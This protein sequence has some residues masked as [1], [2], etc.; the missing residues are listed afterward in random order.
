MK[1]PGFGD[2]ARA[3]HE[4]QALEEER[5]GDIQNLGHQPQPRGGDAVSTAFVLLDLLETNPDD[6]RDFMLAEAELDAATTQSLTN[7]DVYICDHRC[8]S[9]SRSQL[10]GQ[11]METNTNC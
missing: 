4:G 8:K 9:G 11:Y 1:N 3:V 10:L 5:H 6:A 7:S 2:R